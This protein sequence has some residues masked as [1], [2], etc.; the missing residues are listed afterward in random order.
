VLRSKQ[1][2]IAITLEHVLYANPT[3]AGCSQRVILEGRV[4]KIEI[5]FRFF[6]PVVKISF[7]ASWTLA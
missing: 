3:T 2:F 7:E 5:E 6:S 4:G 1:M